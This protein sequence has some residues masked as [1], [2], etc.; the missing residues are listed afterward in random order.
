MCFNDGMSEQFPST[1]PIDE[2]VESSIDHTSS[3]EQLDLEVP[4][5]EEIQRLMDLMH[6]RNLEHLPTME[7]RTNHLFLG[8]AGIGGLLT[9]PKFDQDPERRKEL[10]R[11]DVAKT[12]L[13]IL[14]LA[15]ALGTPD[16]FTAK[17]VEQYEKC[18]R[19]GQNPCV[20]NPS[21]AGFESE[22]P[23]ATE[24][25]AGSSLSEWQAHLKRLYGGNNA[26]R[27]L[28]WM[29]LKLG[30]ELGESI[31]EVTRMQKAIQAGGSPEQVEEYRQR[32]LEEL[33]QVTAWLLGICVHPDARLN[34]QEINLEQILVDLY[35]DGCPNCGQMPCQCGP[36][37]L[38]ET[39]KDE[40][41]PVLLEILRMKDEQRAS[42]QSVDA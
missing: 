42:A 10:L 33:A 14:T 8:H 7:H 20:C 38:E 37:G 26:L 29:G 9:Q 13:R 25:H 19:C 6:D 3:H 24:I 12:Y 2:P 41:A 23:T 39:R 30:A 4:L 15:E 31:T 40:T 17:F 32:A 28:E 18:H 22:Q 21:E 27:D 35:G 36:F 11:I 1:S 16:E 34:N 5:P